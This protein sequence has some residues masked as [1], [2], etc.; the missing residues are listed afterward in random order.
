MGPPQR[1]GHWDFSGQIPVL[2]LDCG[3]YLLVECLNGFYFIWKVLVRYKLA[4]CCILRGKN[5]GR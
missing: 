2:W 4:V 1:V 5:E 3:Q